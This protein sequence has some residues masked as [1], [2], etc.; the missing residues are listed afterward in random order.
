MTVK[1][2][3]GNQKQYLASNKKN[4]KFSSMLQIGNKAII[5]S[6]K[7]YSVRPNHIYL[8]GK[9]QGHNKGPYVTT[10]RLKIKRCFVGPRI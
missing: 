9:Q 10:S 2:L 4:S 7:R 6:M 3:F 8:L 5:R 1:K